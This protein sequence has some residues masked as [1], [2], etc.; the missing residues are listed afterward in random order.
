MG[1]IS[2][3]TTSVGL[4]STRRMALVPVSVRGGVVADDG[5]PADWRAGEDRAVGGMQRL[6]RDVGDLVAADIDD[7]H[8]DCSARSSAR[9][10][11]STPASQPALAQ[12]GDDGELRV[13]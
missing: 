2:G 11:A 8:A 13:G 1:A 9:L 10:I 6:E 5:L 4:S 7:P 3:R 12:I